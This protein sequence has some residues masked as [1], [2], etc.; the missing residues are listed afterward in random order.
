MKAVCLSKEVVVL[1]FPAKVSGTEF[2]KEIRHYLSV[3][4]V[5]VRRGGKW[6]SVFVHEA[7]VKE[8]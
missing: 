5:R 8:L 4:S 6:L 7:P 2:G 1:Y 3:S